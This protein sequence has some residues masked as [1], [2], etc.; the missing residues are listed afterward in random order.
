METIKN[1]FAAPFSD[2]AAAASTPM[3]TAVAYGA[4]GLLIGVLMKG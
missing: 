1:A 2:T 4:L 3:K